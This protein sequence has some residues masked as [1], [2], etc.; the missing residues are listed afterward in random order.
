MNLERTPFAVP[1]AMVLGGCLAL[2]PLPV[3]FSD[4]WAADS[5]AGSEEAQR[6]VPGAEMPAP[7]E[8]PLS[9]QE[10]AGL[11]KVGTPVR[12][13]KSEVIYA[14]LRANGAFRE[15]YVINR[16]DV[17]EAGTLVDFG[18][19]GSVKNLSTTEP[20]QRIGNLGIISVDE[21]IFYYQGNTEDIV[22]PWDVG[23]TYFLDGREVPAS[24]LV[25]ASGDLR[26]HLTTTQ[27]EGVDPVF[28]E[29]FM[30]QITF[31][32][33]GSK[34]SAIDA[35]GATMA[36]AGA[37]RTVTFTVLPGHEGEVDLS[38]HV[39]D[40]TMEGIQIAAL[41]YSSF[42]DLPD[43]S[44]MTDGLNQLSDGV[45]ALS[46]GA[47]ALAIGAWGISAGTGAMEGG[48][49][50][51]GDGLDRLAQ[52]GETLRTGSAA[53]NAALRAF[54]DGMAGVDLSGL[55]QL[56]GLADQ[57][58]G[59]AGDLESRLGAADQSVL[60]LRGMAT[61][62]RQSLGSLDMTALAQLQSGLAVLSSQYESFDEGLHEY[63]D[64]VAELARH[65]GSLRS[66]MEELS[67]GAE[68]L[69]V[70]ADRV[71]Q[72][73][74]ELDG[75]T[76]D[77]PD[78]IEQEMDSLMADYDFPEFQPVSFM[79]KGNTDVTAVQFVM[80]TAAIEPPAEEPQGD[81][82]MQEETWW[83]RLMALFLPAGEE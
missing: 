50:D 72:G 80:T 40:F 32:L 46:G 54:D 81:E 59:V 60:A 3:S 28:F 30:L 58:D 52:E 33:D 57:L 44:E 49:R 37:N 27:G 43:T 68:E 19:Y 15:A 7:G 73:V 17:P 41:P 48:S 74:H 67:S 76:R 29:S 35:D 53:I 25:G 51:V 79:S 42:M 82:P 66:G 10:S 13:S 63:T 2:A 24:E 20:V 75:N 5:Q 45:G 78:R 11:E 22:L 6:Y 26:V 83:D 16:F 36:E 9:L 18:A 1:I 4:A 12:A 65:Y 31:T 70:G 8:I 71:A 77:L 64:G 23:V 61:G 62:L 69:A 56:S 47:D 55:T 38:A 21:G 14:D 34:C 39:E